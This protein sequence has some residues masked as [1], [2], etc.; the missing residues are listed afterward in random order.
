MKKRFAVTTAIIA[1]TYVSRT[2]GRE[3]DVEKT[4]VD[5]IFIVFSV[6]TMS[7]R[8]TN[9]NGTTLSDHFRR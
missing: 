8:L 5:N 7:S 1:Q 3:R 9:Q 6:V 2:D 4:S